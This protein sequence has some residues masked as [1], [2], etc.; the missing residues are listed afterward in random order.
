[1]T[2]S[3]NLVLALFLLAPGFAAYAGLFVTTQREQRLHPAPPAPGSVL[4]LALV[5]LS[6][7]AIHGVWAVVLWLQS[8]W[9]A[10]SDFYLRVPFDPN[11]YADLLNGG[12]ACV[13]NRPCAAIGGAEI[14]SGLCNLLLLS[15]L[16]YLVTCWLMRLNWLEP[17]LRGFLYGWASGLVHDI[18]S[19]PAG[20]IRLTNAFVLTKTDHDG[21][22][23]G[24]EGIL[25][26]MTLNADKEIIA[27]ALTDVT[28]FYLKL[29]AGQF[30]RVVLP[31]TAG[32][33]NIYLER[34]E[35]RNV[36]FQFYDFD[37]PL[38]PRPPRLS[39]ELWAWAKAC[40]VFRPRS[41]SPTS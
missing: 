16:G 6:S 34:S 33:P 7:L 3:Y 12:R 31:N 13:A 35:I 37:A 4:T 26:N 1:L 23:F 9:V 39:A 22:A 11:I 24:Y 2:F 27:L 19:A 28:A 38:E 41:G 8:V 20:K 14:A 5:T 10:H 30:K 40:P 29:K 36:A 32:I 25:Q 15:A 17:R 21:T 18:Q